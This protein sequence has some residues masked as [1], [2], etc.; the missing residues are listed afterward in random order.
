M[1]KLK[2]TTTNKLLV[3]GGTIALTSAIGYYIGKKN[4]DDKT[5]MYGGALVGLLIAQGV[6]VNVVEE[7]K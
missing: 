2:N 1:K 5:L 6:L 7:K 4:G 3:I